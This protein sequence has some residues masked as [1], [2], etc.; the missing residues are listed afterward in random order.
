VAYILGPMESLGEIA[1]LTTA[2][3]WAFTSIF[4]AE[5]G[6]LIGSFRV[7]SIRL[8]LA[9]TIYTIVLLTVYGHLFPDDLNRTQVFWLGLSGVVGLVLGDGCGFKALVMI[10][11]RL[12]TLLYAAAPIMA[13]LIAWVFL[14]EKLG[15]L[16]MAG[17]AITLAGI[18]WV[19]TDRRDTANNSAALHKDHPD[20]GTLVKGVL[21]G[22]GAAL[23][24]A[25]GLVLSKQGMLHAGGSVPAMEAS[26][27]RMLAAL[28]VIWLLSAFRGQFSDTLAAMKNGRAVGLSLGGAF[29]GPFLGVWM[30]L[31]AVRLIP[32]GV[33]ATLNSMTPVMIIPLVILYS[34]EKVSVRAVFGAIAAVFG[35]ALLFIG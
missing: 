20:S 13:V 26:Y 6:K 12:T 5:A 32:T 33:A 16:D 22:L 15:W 25:V 18:A 19:V 23:G 10:G 3:V 31:V 8:L 21:L 7:N 14:G 35:V 29:F 28:P 27:I 34:K 11:P 17:I 30:S 2:V 9:S 24:Q 4:F 1:A